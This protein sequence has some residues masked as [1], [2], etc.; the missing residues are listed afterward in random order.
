[1]KTNI[2][3]LGG[4]GHCSSVL[5]TIMHQNQFTI[6]GII[7]K[8]PELAKGLDESLYLGNDK[9]IPKYKNDKNSFLISIGIMKNAKSRATYI[10]SLEKYKLYFATII[11]LNSYVSKSSNLGSGTVV[12]N[13]VF[14]GPH[15]KIGKHTIVNNGAIVEHHCEIGSN[16][17]LAPGVIM[18]GE[19]IVGNNTF[20]GAGVIIKNKIKIGNNVIIGSG[21][22]IYKDVPNNKIIITKDDL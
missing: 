17:H 18:C 12:L 20:I 22:V 2:I 6:L 7:N 16:T 10:K 14:I 15:S 13:N 11:S 9:M 3:L 5:D 4:G 19:S 1:M 8:T 21:L